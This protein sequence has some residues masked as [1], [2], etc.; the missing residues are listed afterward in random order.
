ME[1]YATD[2]FADVATGIDDTT[3]DEIWFYEAS[4]DVPESD[5]DGE[6]EFYTIGDYAD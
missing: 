5:F 3:T 1:F 2:D 6:L 4:F